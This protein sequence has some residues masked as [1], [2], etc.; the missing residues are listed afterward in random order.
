MKGGKKELLE[1]K[2]DGE[3]FQEWKEEEK[4]SRNIR[5]IE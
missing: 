5:R 2:E 1:L 4:S 3:N